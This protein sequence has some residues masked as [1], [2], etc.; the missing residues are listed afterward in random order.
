MTEAL[1]HA[2]NLLTVV[3]DSSK[4]R[5]QLD[6]FVKRKAAAEQAETKL[7]DLEKQHKEARDEIDLY[8]AKRKGE[9]NEAQ[10]AHDRAAAEAGARIELSSKQ[11]QRFEDWAKDLNKREAEFGKQSTALVQRDEELARLQGKVMARHSELVNS[12]K[13]L[14]NKHKLL[15]AAM[16]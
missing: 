3:A 8:V 5:P 6:E 12:Q 4:L 2:L 1:D 14:D 10:I 9:L 16:E 11:A 7:A 15:R 13:A